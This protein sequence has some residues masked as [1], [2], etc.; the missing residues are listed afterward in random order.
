[1]A[2]NN[3]TIKLSAD[4]AKFQG[5]MIRAGNSTEQAMR[6][7][8]NQA[9]MVGRAMGLMAVS[10]GGALAVMVKASIDSMDKMS[11]L[12]QQTGT[13]TETLSALSYAAKLSGV[14]T[15]ALGSAIVKLSKN[16]SDATQ[17]VGE[18]GKGFKAL[19][20]SVTDSSGALKSSDVIISELAAKFATFKDGA[21]KTA[22]AINIFGKSGAELIPLLNSGA[23][24]IKV[25]TDEAA[26]MGLVMSTETTKA[27]E[28]FNDNL[29]RLSS[30][31]T[32]AAQALTAELLP[33][34]INIQNEFL[35]GMKY[36]KGFIDTILLLGT[37]NPFNTIGN[38]INS[39][40]KELAELEAQ[41]AETAKYQFLSTTAIDREIDGVKRKIGYL[42]DMQAQAALMGGANQSFA[43]SRRLGLVSPTLTAAPNI[44]G[45]KKATG[46]TDAQKIERDAQRFVAK[47]KEQADTFGM[48]STAVLEY[49]MS[50]S[51]FPQI[52]KDQALAL[53]QSIA[54]QTAAAAEDKAFAEATER[55]MADRERDIARL[56]SN[57]PTMV[58]KA[59]QDDLGKLQALLAQGVISEQLYAEAVIS[60]FGL[61]NDKINEG[62]TLA[63]DLEY[64][65]TNAFKN[66]EDSLIS[67]VKTGKIDFSSLADS[68]IEDMA[69]I[70]I[71]QSI[72][73]PMMG[74]LP[75]FFG[76]ANG[77]VFGGGGVQAF[78]NGGAFSNSIVSSPT[79][80]KFANGTGLMGE[81]GP[82]A[83]MP[84]RRGA[85]GKLGVHAS[86]FGGGNSMVVNI[87]ES[88]G[89][90]GQ[91][92]RRTENGID[93]L[94]VFVEK[95]KGAIAGDINRG[96][97]AV[98][99]AMS[100]TYGLNRVA[101]AY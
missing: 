89:N 92:S 46:L 41:R 38:N 33:S 85:D 57:T 97:G 9:K 66:M 75:G 52:Y 59:Q 79:L 72:I 4:I 34:L 11:K 26:R 54:A 36:G 39:L 44:A 27:A 90:G 67:F 60:R 42:K 32:A 45:T 69:R 50:L 3:L 64:V 61:V 23:D 73:K 58:L 7:M 18:A 93:I 71:Q 62:K 81:A 49:Q 6:K 63:Q 10:A 78:A 47:L 65:Y 99:S 80:F 94:D 56:I 31:S 21:E 86:G 37:I 88:P 95:V 12:A 17:G 29:T 35:T 91:Q 98:P 8:E 76:F 15:N 74:M 87:I 13:T 30:L 43:E 53:Q 83:I 100:Q 55:F 24:G 40:T 22:L 96:S 68:I 28:L 1:M 48:S 77:G 82:E 51:K 5:D 19:G 16:M 2:N 70:A 20:I 101:G 84:L 14:S 25:M